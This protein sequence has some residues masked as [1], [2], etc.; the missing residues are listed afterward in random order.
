[1]T[2]FTWPLVVLLVCL[3]FDAQGVKIPEQVL[4]SIV[5]VP[6]TIALLIVAISWVYLSGCIH[7]YI[8]NH[9]FWFENYLEHLYK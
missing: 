8:K 3:L 4:M 6:C 7:K 2:M 1:M 5:T 9:D